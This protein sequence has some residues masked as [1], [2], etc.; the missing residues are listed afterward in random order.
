M[1]SPQKDFVTF[2]GAETRNSLENGNANNTDH[3]S[4][5]SSVKCRNRSAERY[6]DNIMNKLTGPSSSA[7]KG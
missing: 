3:A 6:V 5:D 2:N 7:K 1:E 4:D